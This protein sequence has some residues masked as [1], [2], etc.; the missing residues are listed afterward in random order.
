MA[1][2]RQHAFLD[3]FGD[4]G[5][6]LSRKGTSSHF[7]VTAV[8]VE[9]DKVPA[10]E[11][12]LEPIRKR[13]FQTGE[14]RS[15]R[16]AGDDARRKSILAELSGVDF[17]VYAVVVDKSK[18]TSVGF[19]Y[20]PSF[21]KFLNGLVYS[22]LYR[23]FPNLHLTAHRIGDK[24]FMRSFVTYVQK[25]HIPDLFG[26]ADFGFV[27]SKSNLM[28]Q[29]A[30]FVCGSLAR[31]FD[32]TVLS[33]AGQDFVQILSQRIIGLVKW[34]GDRP[35]LT[36]GPLKEGDREVDSTVYEL[37]A[38]LANDFIQRNKGS[39]DPCVRE[40]VS[41]LQYLLFHAQH[42]HPLHYVPTREIMQNVRPGHTSRAAVRHFR[43]SIVAKLRDAGV[44][45]AS[46]SRGYKLP[47]CEQD[48]LD[49]VGHSNV[50]VRPILDRIGRCHRKVLL[51]TKGKC[52][53][54]SMEP[55]Q[56]MKAVLPDTAP[57]A[58]DHE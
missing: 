39:R 46:S 36:H 12:Q 47:V 42:V 20:R 24:E 3:E 25:R 34:P 19:T 37:A 17:H 54:L 22:E 48:L 21:Y 53:L 57:A 5:L 27:S 44:L 11:A 16:V 51:A 8:I 32:R 45:I 10:L 1:I 40:Q 49:Y 26:E 58:R 29:L 31:R 35:P 55:F 2:A 23:V 33:S 18:L 7:L 15:R 38:N 4:S 50:V 6:D 56:Y 41:C 9:K 43:S 30:D 13:H 52:D 14:M 28:I